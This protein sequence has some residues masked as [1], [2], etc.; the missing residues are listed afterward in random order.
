MEKADRIKSRLRE[1]KTIE[2]LK[3]VWESEVD[4]ITSLP[5]PFRSHVINLK[6][7]RKDDFTRQIVNQG[8]G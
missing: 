2:E 4:A 3:D 7:W 1:A 6:D 5:E 8:A